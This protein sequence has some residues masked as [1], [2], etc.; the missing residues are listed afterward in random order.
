MKFSWLIEFNIKDFTTRYSLKTMRTIVFEIAFEYFTTICNTSC[1]SMNFPILIDLGKFY[2]NHRIMPNISKTHICC[3]EIS[4]QFYIMTPQLF[5]NDSSFH[6]FKV[7]QIPLLNEQLLWFKVIILIKI[8]E[9]RM[10][11]SIDSFNR[12]MLKCLLVNKL[13]KV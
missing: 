1:N 8:I 2:E 7:I 11:K 10:Y 5:I 6:Q 3:N 9:F 4:L 13:N 12:S